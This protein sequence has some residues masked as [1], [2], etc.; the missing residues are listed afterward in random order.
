[1]NDNK[2]VYKI[3]KYNYADQFPDLDSAALPAIRRLLLSGEYILGPEVTQ[4]EDDFAR[5]L[6]VEHAVGVNSGTDALI[7]ALD[8]LGIGPGD[9]VVTVANSFHATAQAI[10]RCGASPVLVDCGDDD[11]LISLDQVAAAVN[12]RTRAVVVVHLFG[13]AADVESAAALCDHRGLFLIEDC[14]QAAGARSRGKRVGTTSHAGCWSFAPAKNLAAAGDGGAV[15]TA[16]GDTARQVRLLRHFGQPVQNRHDLV[17]Y[18]SRLDS[19]QA[20]LLAQK[21]KH[22]DAW[23]TARARVADG[24]RQRLSELPLSVQEQ[25]G[26]GEHVYH[27]FQVRAESA[28]VR[29]GLVNCLQDAGVDAVVRYPVPLHLQGAFSFL[30]HRRG[31]F[32]IAEALAQQTLCLPIRPDLSERDLDYVC[33]VIAQFFGNS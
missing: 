32:P 33:A 4:F 6:D 19:L 9:E 29:D 23:N 16:H 12:S 31:A 15:T 13:R 5:F 17:G 10:V 25:G 22:L 26:P 27:L 7:L 2:R 28:E 1:M 14:A 11:F 24:Y 20:L 18:N 3:P 21:L 8:A 30:G